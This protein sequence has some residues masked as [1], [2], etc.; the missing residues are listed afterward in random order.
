MEPT[1]ETLQ[2][3][4][5]SKLGNHISDAPSTQTCHEFNSALRPRCRV[6]TFGGSYLSTLTLSLISVLT[7]D[8]EVAGKG[9]IR[10]MQSGRW[11]KQMKG[12]DE[13]VNSVPRT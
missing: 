6:V 12:S 8:L 5:R 11:L 9:K 13:A 10:N 1:R 4:P 2:T 7:G 3:A